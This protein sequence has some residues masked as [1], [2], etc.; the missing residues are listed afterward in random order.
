M[1]KKQIILPNKEYAKAPE[2][3]IQTKIGLESSEELLREGD[4]N[5]L[6]DIDQLYND[7][8]NESK[9][10]KIYGK[11]KMIFRNLYSGSTG[12]SDLT[13]T[14]YL[15][16]DGASG[17]NQGFLPYNEFAFLRRDLQRE[18][19][20]VPTVSTGS[21]MGTYDSS[22]VSTIGTGG[23]RDIS[24]MEA[25]Y[26][27]WNFYLSYVHDSDP[28]HYIAYTLTGGTQTPVG[29]KA[30]HGIPTRVSDEG[31]YYKL[32]TPVPHGISEN[33]FILISGA[34]QYN[35]TAYSIMRV[36]DEI[37]DSEKY[38]LNINKTEL[39]GRTLNGVVLIKRCL[40]KEDVT[41]TTCS[42]YVHKHKTLTEVD[43]YIMDKAGFESPI[44]EDEKKLLF[45]NSVGE[46]DVL[47]ER[48][49]MESVI[50]DFREPFVLTGI[51]NNLDYT[52]NEIYLTTIFRNGSGYFEYP[53][54][55]GYKF[56]LHNS[57]VDN[58]YSGTTANE[59][60]I[61]GTSWNVSG[62]TFTSGN[63]LPTGTVLTGAFVEYDHVNMKERIISEALHKITNPVNIFDFNQNDSSYYTN[64][65]TSNKLGLYYQPHYKIKLR[66]ESPYIES[67]DTKNIYNLPDNAEFY[68]K[69]KT[70]RW[71]D[72]Y[73]HGYVDDLGFGTDFP[74][75]NGQ[76]YVMSDINFYLRNEYAFL[77][78][79]DGIREFGKKNTNC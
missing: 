39:S 6:L 71:R 26:F 59:T 57:W 63:T 69:T 70:W 40:D 60:T 35:T 12:Y 41:G 20:S 78:K 16:G 7:E 46:N 45:E 28:E 33:E 32:T 10:Y 61:S 15:N 77:N 8:R 17:D 11:L 5:I 76:H 18:V 37:Y 51:T 53:P 24:I 66:Q 52:P 64:V 55:V 14:L 56:H 27:N 73:D 44:F 54:K 1:E 34:S 79:S 2:K 49:R 30:K 72:I 21:T 43:A 19:I 22:G 13:K 23:H 58:H 50:F 68:E 75:V 74:F 42:Y 29:T 36:G 47:V 38:V 3:D 31:T 4:R 48:N 67:S 65:N 62:I 9:K 25:P